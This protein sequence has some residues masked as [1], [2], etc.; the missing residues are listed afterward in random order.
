[1]NL[2]LLNNTDELCSGQ[3]ANVLEDDLADKDL[4]TRQFN[5]LGLNAQ[6]R[7]LEN[8]GIGDLLLADIGEDNS[9][10]GNNSAAVAVTIVEVIATHPSPK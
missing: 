9:E 4:S 3:F 10:G 1:V 6:I 7:S 5:A 8:S 2:N